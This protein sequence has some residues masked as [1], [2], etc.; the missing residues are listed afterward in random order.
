M[1]DYKDIDPT[2]KNIMESM[3][4]HWDG[5]GVLLRVRTTLP[6]FGIRKLGR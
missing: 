5:L 1:A 2:E 6:A 3:G 4:Y